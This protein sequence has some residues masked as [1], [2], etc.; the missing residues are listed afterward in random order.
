[1]N[2]VKKTFQYGDQ[3]VTLET[4]RIARQASGS[5]LISMGSTSVLCTVVA[6]P[7]AKPGQAFFPLG[8][9]YIE[10]T[11]SVGKIPGGFF[12]R[13]ARPS[14]KETLTSRLIDRPIRPL[15]ADGFMNEVQVVCTVMSA[16][17]ETDP[18]IPAMI[19]TSAA[20]A[21][22]GCPF[23][24][25]IGGAR[26]GFTEASGY[27]LNPTYSALA[28]SQLDMVVA[29]TKDAVL[30]V[31][32]QAKEL[33]EDQMLGA[34]LFAHQE[35]QT[36]I[37]AINELVAEAGKPRWEWQAPE[38]DAE[39][40]AAVQAAASGPLGEAYRITEKAARYERV[41]QVKDEVVAQLATDDGPAP[42]DVKDIFKALEKNIVRSRI[43]AGEPRID[44]RDNRTVR[45][46]ACEVDVLSKAHGSALFT[47][48][49]T[50]AIGAVTLGST[51]D[52][53]IIDALEG[54]RRDPFM[55]HYN[56]PPYSVGEA[57][58]IG[59]TSRREVG[60][61]RLARRGLAAVLPG[62]EEFPYTIRV[63][64][65]ITESNGSSSMASVCVGSLSMM[66]AGVP[67]S[68]PVAG[69][70]MGLV[71]DGNQFAV[72]TDILGDEDH[73]GDMDFKVA[74]T[75]KGVTALQMDIKIEGINE[76]IMERALEQALEAR[77]HILGQ[78]NTV[79]DAPREITSDNAPSMSSLKIDQDKI[80]DIIGKGGATIRQITEES[81]AT[82][83]INDDGT[84]KVFGQN[85]AS[86]DAAIEMIMAITA[87]AEVGEIYT[88]TVARIVDF[89]AF[90]TILPG[91]D[92]LVHISQIADERVENVS[93]Y[94]SEGQEV[95]V[96][97][98]DVDQRGRIKL[99]M[100]EI[101]A[102]ATAPA[103]PE[104]QDDSAEPES[105]EQE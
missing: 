1:M 61:G 95:Q 23:N 20:L 63:V 46:I 57:G 35:M 19:G 70:A 74:G 8:V 36:V 102:E 12:K 30:M 32:S 98:L 73:L 5:V 4:G 51:R 16:D 103:D 54:E 88:G 59:F 78:M 45:A 49:E 42:D 21:I 44:G 75:A 55:L 100:R 86:R 34:V 67:L 38:A 6:D 18:D 22:S 79:L 7:K 37:N 53:Q 10:K 89:G 40:V 29:G 39:L 82:V 31:E 24:G 15:F 47:R 99:S 76:E 3:E 84:V 93:D 48:G 2:V 96:K 104:G 83:D 56:F 64:S 62:E 27:I 43:L 72:L 13:E 14:E 17:K 94:L 85:A 92:G 71:K 60:H 58:R 87:E 77:L 33:T 28:D 65:E 50:Q 9:H 91:K 80:R 25:P 69:I 90:V 97:V 81:G 41:G 105:L 68:A 52:A 11:Y 101:A 26:V 66:A